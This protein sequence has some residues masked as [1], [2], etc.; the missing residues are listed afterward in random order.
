MG[1]P[2]YLFFTSLEALVTHAKT[3]GDCMMIAGVGKDW[4]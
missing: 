2:S 1:A 3:S 4:Y